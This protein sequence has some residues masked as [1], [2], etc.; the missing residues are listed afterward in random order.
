MLDASAEA[1]RVSTASSQASDDVFYDCASRP[2]SA[3]PS[4]DAATSPAD[5]HKTQQQQPRFRSLTN[6][7][8][9]SGSTSPPASADASAAADAM[10]TTLRR[11]ATATATAAAS[12]KHA[13]EAR[14]RRAA[15][16]M[17]EACTTGVSVREADERR[18][19]ALGRLLVDGRL[20]AAAD[21]QP[22]RPPRQTAR[23]DDGLAGLRQNAI[24]HVASHGRLH[25]AAPGEQ[26]RLKAAARLAACGSEPPESDG[27]ALSM[28]G[29]RTAHVARSASLEARVDR[30]TR[31]A[32]AQWLVCFA[33]VHFDADQGPALDLVYPHV[34]FSA[35]ERAAI[36]F[37]AMPDS[38]ISELYDS[39]YTF[40]F[41][42]DP[43]RLGLPKDRIF[44][45]GHVF[46]RQ[47]RDPLMRR[48]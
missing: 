5:A 8:V 37:S 26:P 33:S 32:L 7:R 14:A 22:T 29:D 39:V 11:S 17:A 13:V 12:A 18:S 28:T 6:S 25:A 4:L 46:F 19:R 16:A 35:S 21:G 27:R 41:R 20:G 45:Y 36:S 15:R 10:P 40:H 24:H 2:P 9:P 34:P 48:G 3:K 43:V 31:A 38:T 23:S 47:K 1:P 44:L 42:V 30:R